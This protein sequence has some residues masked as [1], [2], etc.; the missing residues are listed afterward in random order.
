MEQPAAP[1]PAA[2]VPTKP[3]CVPNI[4]AHGRKLRYW[5]GGVALGLGLI[6]ATRIVL[7]RLPAIEMFGPGL[8]FLAAALGYFQARERTCVFLAAAGQKEEDAEGPKKFDRDQLALLKRQ[9]TRVTL[10]AVGSALAVTAVAA[11]LA[12][13]RAR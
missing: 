7:L 6:G 5:G 4:G 9:A 10:Q 3:N 13:W 8:A 11:A 12:A 1:A 2:E